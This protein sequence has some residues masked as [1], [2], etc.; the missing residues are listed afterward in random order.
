MHDVEWQ[1]LIR[2]VSTTGQFFLAQDELNQLRKTLS[3]QDVVALYLAIRDRSGRLEEEWRDEFVD[4]FPASEDV[5]P[6]PL[7]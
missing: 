1:A 4:A 2:S 3:D 6:A 5:L 7:A